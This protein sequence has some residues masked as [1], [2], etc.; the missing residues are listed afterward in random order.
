MNCAIY[1]YLPRTCFTAF[2][3]SCDKGLR[4]VPTVFCFASKS[5]K[6]FTL[7]LRPLRRLLI[8][9]SNC[10]CSAIR[11]STLWNQVWL[12]FSYK[13]KTLL[14]S[15]SL[16]SLSPPNLPTYSLNICSSLPSPCPCLFTFNAWLIT[17]TFF[18]AVYNNCIRELQKHIPNA[19][20][21]LVA[22]GL[23]G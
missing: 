12:I 14:F 22:C 5:F 20:P 2:H 21:T 18:N 19:N 1:F 13:I 9:V 10:F 7:L 3:S 4:F 23:T 16:L 6:W 17:L 15:F 8:S 11:R